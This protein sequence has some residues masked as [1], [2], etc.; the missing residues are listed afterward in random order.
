MLAQDGVTLFI[1]FNASNN[2][3]KM[4]EAS[5]DTA[6]ARKERRSAKW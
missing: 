1:Y 6:N 3:A 2:V 5:L 4:R